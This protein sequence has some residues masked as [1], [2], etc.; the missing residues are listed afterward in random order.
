MNRGADKP[1]FRVFNTKQSWSLCS[2][3]AGLEVSDEG[4]S[5]KKT[6]HYK[7]T[8]RILL[9]STFKHLD[10]GA[11]TAGECGTLYLLD[12]SSKIL[13]AWDETYRDL[14]VI[15]CL[16]EWLSKPTA[17]SYNGNALY[18][19][20]HPNGTLQSD[21]GFAAS[22]PPRLLKVSKTTGQVIWHVGGR[23]DSSGF[24]LK[25]PHPFLPETI[26]VDEK[27]NLFAWDRCNNQAVLK[28]DAGGRLIQ[29]F[30]E[31]PLKER[32]W[33]EV[34]YSKSCGNARYELV[35]ETQEIV[36]RTRTPA[37]VGEPG[38]KRGQIRG[39][40]VSRLLEQEI[41][42][43]G[44]HKFV[45]KSEVPADTQILFSYSV[46]KSMSDERK[47]ESICEKCIGPVSLNDGT[48]SMLIRGEGRYLR[49]KAELIGTP[50]SAPRLGSVQVF[51]GNESYLD[52]L[53]E[54]YRDDE[55]SGEF[56]GRFLD[57][58][59][60]FLSESE[61]TIEQFPG[62]LDIDATSGEFLRWLADWFAIPFVPDWP[63]E[64]LRRL[65]K[66]LPYLYR[67]RGTRSA[68]EAIIE[69][70]VGCKPLAI[71]ESFRY[72]SL[73]DEELRRTFQNVYGNGPYHFSV[74]FRPESSINTQQ[75]DMLKLMLDNEVPAHV[76]PHYVQLEDVT[77]LDGHVYLG[78][79]SRIGMPK[80]T[81]L[82]QGAKLTRNTVL[83]DPEPAG[84]IGRYARLSLDATLS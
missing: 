22:D 29:S 59:Q 9:K 33:E 20:N 70:V 45:I 43:A 7:I 51:F 12:R 50:Q 77:I 74:L 78:I 49:F 23:N 82:D 72:Q 58:Y 39:T 8:K 71:V 67:L 65:L 60:T 30:K 26:F 13:Y 54:I 38:E 24:C 6:T 80:P 64:K 37:F 4:L 66:K 62:Y 42:G 81:G 27:Q 2:G 35:P 56:L 1:L 73:Q 79:N 28:L 36:V 69:I 47:N 16:Q 40:Y 83:T 44:W 19:V 18:I 76:S 17:L 10:I 57:L 5:F 25:L 63:I 52:Y 61:Q 46:F 55:K 68:I 31:N 75:M 53:P 3:I 48:T 11:I 84:Q 14:S 15:S 41:N 21:G 34:F 32:Q